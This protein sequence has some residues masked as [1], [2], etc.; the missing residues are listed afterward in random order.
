MHVVTIPPS[1]KKIH[2][3][4]LEKFTVSFALCAQVDVIK[5]EKH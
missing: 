1:F 4:E 3:R 2:R 5:I